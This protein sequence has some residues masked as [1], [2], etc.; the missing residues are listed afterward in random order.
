MHSFRS[1]IRVYYVCSA[2]QQTVAEMQQTALLHDAAERSV[3]CSV[4][5]REEGRLIARPKIV[6][7]IRSRLP[8]HSIEYCSPLCAM[9]QSF[10]PYFHSQLHI[11]KLLISN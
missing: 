5:Y 1:A 2:V 7:R 6:R 3:N 10:L 8:S 11:P 9:C 4:G